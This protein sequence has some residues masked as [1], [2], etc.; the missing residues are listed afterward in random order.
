MRIAITGANGFIGNNLLK[1][2]KACGHETI[3]IIRKSAIVPD[4]DVEIREVDYYDALSLTEN[5]KDVDV[6]IH[7]AGKTKSLNAQEMLA[8]NVGI[9]Q[10]IV[11]A[12]NTLNHPIHLIFISSQAASRASTNNKPINEDETP[13]P[14]TR[15]GKSKIGRAHV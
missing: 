7:N 14:L 4:H 6:L 9:T 10:R 13:R 15:Y 3:A 11:Q 8:A 2:F 1:H 5:L 12:I